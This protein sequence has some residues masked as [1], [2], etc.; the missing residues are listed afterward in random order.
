MILGTFVKALF[1]LVLAERELNPGRVW[2]GDSGRE[3]KKALDIRKSIS[4]IFYPLSANPQFQN[5]EI[6]HFTRHDRRELPDMVV[7]FN[8]LGVLQHNVITESPPLDTEDEAEDER[9]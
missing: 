2:D 4:V 5:I 6:K 7:G 9:P 3:W 1:P 8:S